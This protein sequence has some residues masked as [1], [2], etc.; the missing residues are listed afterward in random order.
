MAEDILATVQDHAVRRLSWSRLKTT[1]LHIQKDVLRE[2]SVIR[3]HRQEI[4]V[5]GDTIMVFADDA[6]QFNWSHPC[7]YLLYSARTG[8]PYQEVNAEFPPYLTKVPDGLVAFH[9]PI[10]LDIVERFWP[11]KPGRTRFWTSVSSTPNVASWRCTVSC[12]A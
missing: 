4:P 3:A 12:R 10:R 6:P 5:K 7:R 11:I 1:N 9:Q 8:E 2:G